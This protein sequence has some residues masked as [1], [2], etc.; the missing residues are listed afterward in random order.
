MSQ[1]QLDSLPAD[2]LADRQRLVN[3]A[4][5]YAREYGLCQEFERALRVLMPEM[6][7]TDQYGDTAWFDTDGMSCRGYVPQGAQAQ[8][9]ENGYDYDGYDRDGFNRYGTDHDGLTRYEIEHAN[10]EPVFRFDADGFDE[11]GRDRHGYNKDGYD[12]DGW[13]SS[14]YHRDGGSRRKG[15]DATA[16]ELAAV[17]EAFNPTTYKPTA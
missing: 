3:A 15:R 4:V 2:V 8:Y 13:N 6:S 7:T 16:E 1:E 12:P 9:N 10:D 14:G 17:V 11:S 5:R